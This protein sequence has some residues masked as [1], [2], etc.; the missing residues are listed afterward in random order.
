MNPAPMQVVADQN[1][2]VPARRSLDAAGRGSAWGGW[3]RLGDPADLRLGV[4]DLDHQPG[5]AF[6]P[7][8]DP[9][10]LVRVMHIPE[11]LLAVGVK[12]SGRDHPGDVRSSYPDPVQPV[13]RL[14]ADAGGTD[15]VGERDLQRAFERPQPVHPLDV[16]DKRIPGHLY[17]RGHVVSFSGLG[18]VPSTPS[19]A[20]RRVSGGACLD[21]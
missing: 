14:G 11:H 5:V 13:A 10:R 8:L 15:Y 21:L 9:D 2:A 17:R 19:W 3:D 20:A 1:G 18:I 7:Q 4:G 16:D 12:T 6:V